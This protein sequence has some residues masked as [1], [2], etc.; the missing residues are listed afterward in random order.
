MQELECD[1]EDDV[2][3][4]LS[5]DERD[6][7]A[8]DFTADTTVTLLSNVVLDSGIEIEHPRAV[9]VLQ[10]FLSRDFSFM[11]ADAIKAGIG[12]DL[13]NPSNVA[14]CRAICNNSLFRVQTDCKKLDLNCSKVLQ[15]PMV[16]Q[17]TF[18]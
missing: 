2:L 13:N 9:L 6:T 14:F 3:F 12:I 4:D 18:L 11:S 5:G 17:P 15:Q 7:T 10:N 8:L 16:S 1:S